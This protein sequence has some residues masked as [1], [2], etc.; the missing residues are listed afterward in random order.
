MPHPLPLKHPL[1]RQAQEK[2]I[3]SILDGIRPRI[4]PRFGPRVPLR[5]LF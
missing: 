3:A 4:V 2:R 1:F 5:R